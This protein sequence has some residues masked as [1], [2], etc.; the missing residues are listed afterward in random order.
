MMQLLL[1]TRKGGGGGGGGG[2]G[3]GGSR[4]IPLHPYSK[5]LSHDAL[6]KKLPSLALLSKLNPWKLNAEFKKEVYREK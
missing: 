6:M 2:G 5:A 3:L 4:H 1:N